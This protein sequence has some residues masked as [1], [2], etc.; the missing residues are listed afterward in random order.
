MKTKLGATNEPGMGI[1]AGA[2]RSLGI[3]TE[4]GLVEG[5]GQALLPVPV[6]AP[7]EALANGPDG[8]ILGAPFSCGA[9]ALDWLRANILPADIH[10]IILYGLETF[11]RSPGVHQIAM[12]RGAPTLPGFQGKPGSII[13][14]AGNAFIV[15]DFVGLAMES[16]FGLPGALKEVDIASLARNLCFSLVQQNG[17]QA[18]PQ[19]TLLGGENGRICPGTPFIRD[20]AVFGYPALTHT[21]KMS[22]QALYH[23]QVPPYPGFPD[24]IGARVK[25]Y[26]VSLQLLAAALER[27]VIP[28]GG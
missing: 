26:L 8:P 27:P 9:A 11:D 24:V 22:M 21:V 16:V 6:Q 5:L 14:P 3:A 19:S 18:L 17:A 20:S 28:Y 2:L 23:V 13:I 10:P 7:C 4:P 12:T 25:G 1:G 15:T